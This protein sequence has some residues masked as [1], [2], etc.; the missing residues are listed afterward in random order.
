MKKGKDKI[1]ER[2][3]LESRIE[4]VEQ[5]AVFSEMKREIATIND[6]GEVKDL[7][8]KAEMLRGYAKSAGK[9]LEL[10]NACAEMRLRYERRAGEL[11]MEQGITAGNPQL[12]PRVTIGS[13]P[14][15]SD[16]GITRN[17]SSKWQKIARIPGKLFDAFL[18]EMT[19]K[20]A[21]ITTSSA[22]QLYKEVET[23]EGRSNIKSAKV[24]PIT[25]DGR[26]VQGDMI[27]VLKQMDREF[28]DLILTDPPFGLGQTADIAFDNRENMSKPAG[29]WDDLDVARQF[30]MWAEV[31]RHAIKPDGSLY[32]FVADRYI[33]EMWSA[34][35]E[36]GFKMQGL[37]LWQK[38]NPPPSVRL[39]DYRS[40]VEYLIYA[41]AS[42]D[43]TLN[44]LGQDR[45][46]KCRDFP[47][48]A[49]KERLDHPTQKPVRLLKEYIEASTNVGGLVLDPFAGV[50]STGAAA[51][52]LNRRYL[53]I[54]RDDHYYR[55]TCIRL[56]E[57]IR[58]SAKVF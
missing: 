53:L 21:E 13:S 33:A 28:A 24:N 20:S 52:E 51:S 27:Q 31:F 37:H 14:S 57:T 26:A 29:D 18:E 38:T 30:P 23:E 36:Q 19:Q 35:A 50:G 43:Y 55:Q 16:F 56:Q 4:T 12:S 22:L 3:S 8:D 15:L 9:S 49:G 48:C 2:Q 58:P 44:W 25:S 5:I 39:R 45:M 34:L 11:L 7:R 1:P 54:E 10:Q 6:M 42:D 32:C 46:K 41:T 47:I 40:N 17:Q